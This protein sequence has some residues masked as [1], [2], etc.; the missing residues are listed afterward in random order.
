MDEAKL[1]FILI[2]AVKTHN[3]PL[4]HKCNGEMANLFFAFNGQNYARYLSWFEM[5]LTN[6]ELTHPG[7][8]KL[9]DNGVLGAARSL[10]PGAL[11][12][13]DKTME[14]SFM[15]SAKGSGG[16]SGIFQQPGAYQRWCIT[17]SAR[18][19]CYEQLLDLCGMVNDPELPKS[20]KH[21][22]LDRSQIR[23]SEEAVQK[24][25]AAIHNFTNPWTIANKDRL[26]SVASGAPG[27]PEIK[28]CL[29][30]AQSK[31]FPTSL[32]DQG[33]K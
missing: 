27:S 11:N 7:S 22:E 14:E 31:V 32:V 4:L 15:K 3:R 16:L 5:S 30:D 20:G 17:T 6:I 1:V 23:K 26:Y 12:P 10:I 29:L 21:R 9:L 25:M 24:V 8:T 2:H 33:L 19:R 18:A 13:I 28:A